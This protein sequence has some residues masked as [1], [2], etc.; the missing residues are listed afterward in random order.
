MTRTQILDESAG[1]GWRAALPGVPDGQITLPRYHA[2][3]Y[4]FPPVGL[5]GSD[6][7]ELWWWVRRLAD[8]LVLQV[9]TTPQ[10]G[11]GSDAFLRRQV[12]NTLRRAE[13]WWERLGNPD[14]LRLNQSLYTRHDKWKDIADFPEFLVCFLL[15]WAWLALPTNRRSKPAAVRLVREHLRVAVQRFE[16]GEIRESEEP[17]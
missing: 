1:E 16:N 2:K 3:G 6:A 5:H 12:K 13:R 15:C 17:P 11:K 4:N 7:P 8:G 14:P 9:G 10:V